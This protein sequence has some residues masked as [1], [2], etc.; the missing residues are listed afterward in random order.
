MAGHDAPSR[1][2]YGMSVRPAGLRH[3]D[4]GRVDPPPTQSGRW[5]PRFDRTVVLLHGG[6]VSWTHWVRNIGPLVLASSPS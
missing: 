2:W 6:S 5:G 3:R 1:R 4:R